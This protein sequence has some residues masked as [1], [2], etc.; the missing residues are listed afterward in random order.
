MEGNALTF[1]QI[2]RLRLFVSGHKRRSILAMSNARENGYKVIAMEHENEAAL[3][4][5]I[6]RDLSNEHGDSYAK[7]KGDY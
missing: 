7:N 6:L 1:D 2:E 5:Q 3:A 4:S